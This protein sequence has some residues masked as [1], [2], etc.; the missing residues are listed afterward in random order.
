MGRKAPKKYDKMDYFEKQQFTTEQAKKYG[1]DLVTREVNGRHEMTDWEASN[2]AVTK[3]MANDYDTRR[4]IEA[5]QS[6]GDNK[7]RDLGK[8]ISNIEE[9]VAAE[10]FM[11]KT[12]VKKLG[13]TGDYSSANDEGNVTNYWVDRANGKFR[14]SL[15]ADMSSTTEPNEGTEVSNQTIERSPSFNEVYGETMKASTGYQPEAEAQGLLAASVSAIAGSRPTIDKAKAKQGQYVLN[16][17]GSSTFE[18]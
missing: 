10:R 14:D 15:L 8:G 2:R 16:N 6:A 9:A 13:A 5:A 11:A 4:S 7:A 1:I 3:A 12:H 17:L 18:V